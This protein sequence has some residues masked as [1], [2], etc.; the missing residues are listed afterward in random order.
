MNFYIENV[1]KL[2]SNLVRWVLHYFI[3]GGNW[4]QGPHF[5]R[6][7]A[8]AHLLLQLSTSEP[9]VGGR[10]GTTS[11]FLQQAGPA[12]GEEKGKAWSLQS[13]VCASLV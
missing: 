3:L 12:K 8:H 10:K 1:G 4:C 7:N 5:F 2:C 11:I 9:R 6:L 13:E